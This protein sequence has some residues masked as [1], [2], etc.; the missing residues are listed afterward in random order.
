MLDHIL[1][2]RL[3]IITVKHS[4]IINISKNFNLTPLLAE[5]YFNQIK[6]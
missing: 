6:V 2:N 3:T 4:I 5:V 1:V